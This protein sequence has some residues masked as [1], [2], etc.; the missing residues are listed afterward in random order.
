MAIKVMSCVTIRFDGLNRMYGNNSCQFEHKLKQ[1]DNDMV[2]KSSELDLKSLESTY[3]RALML[4]KQGKL[5]EAAK[6]YQ[7]TL[8]IDSSDCCGAGV[9]LAAMKLGPVP[10]KASDAYVATLFDQHAETFE[11]ILV[12]QL[13]YHVP[14]IAS[15]CLRE[16]DDRSFAQM[17]DLGCGTGLGGEA[18]VDVCNHITGVDVSEGMISKAAEKE[19]Y[20]DLFVAEIGNF[21]RQ[22]ETNHW[23]LILALD[24]LPYFGSLNDFFQGVQN[25]MTNNGLFVFSSEK[26]T[27]QTA[28]S[29]YSVNQNHRFVHCEAYIRTCL[30]ENGFDIAKIV[31]IVVRNEEG[32][33][34]HGQLII[35]QCND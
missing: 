22:S 21:L 10:D 18:L 27:G 11:A 28:D 12:G 1:D 35:A 9:R 4:E 26:L 6:A 17:L 7:A 33:P 29:G 31:E 24:V 15:N 2:K 30:T 14:I 16:F 3:N 25:K 8:E 23:D 19:I 34:V 13:D 20:D 5:E 32:S